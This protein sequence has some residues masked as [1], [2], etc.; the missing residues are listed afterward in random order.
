MSPGVYAEFSGWSSKQTGSYPET[1]FGFTGDE[2]D[3]PSG[4]SC[5]RFVSLVS[6]LY[7][8]TFLPEKGHGPKWD[9]QEQC[10]NV[11][12]W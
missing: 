7:S 8:S 9:Y 4:I 5:P 11:A 3:A 10:A 6:C 1:L 2:G 12:T